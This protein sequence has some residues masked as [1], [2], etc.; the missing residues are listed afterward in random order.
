MIEDTFTLSKFHFHIWKEKFTIL[1]KGQVPFCLQYHSLLNITVRSS[2]KHKQHDVIDDLCLPKPSRIH[3][4]QGRKQYSFVLT[5][6]DIFFTIGQEQTSL[7]NQCIS[8]QRRPHARPRAMPRALLSF[9][10]NNPFYHKQYRRQRVQYFRSPNNGSEV[11]N[12]SSEVGNNR[13]E[14]QNNKLRLLRPVRSAQRTTTRTI[15]RIEVSDGSF[16]LHFSR[17]FI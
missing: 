10:N 15:W 4:E 3:H 5:F 17:S 6:T 9:T 16:F 13:S 2:F 1:K 11:E 7:L 8:T 14:V 12:N